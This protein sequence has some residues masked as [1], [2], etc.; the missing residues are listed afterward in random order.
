MVG[1][2]HIFDLHVVVVVVVDTVV[3]PLD[4]NVDVVPD[5]FS[6]TAAGAGTQGDRGRGQAR[7]RVHGSRG[8]RLGQHRERPQ[9]LLSHLKAT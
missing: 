8:E 4:D 5:G 1:G 9:R 7:I 6:D 3:G 2:D